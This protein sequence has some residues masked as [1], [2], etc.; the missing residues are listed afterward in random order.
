LKRTNLWLSKK[1]T[2]SNSID[3]EHNCEQQHVNSFAP[4]EAATEEEEKE[5]EEEEEDKEERVAQAKGRK[6]NE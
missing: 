2:S 1:Y 4:L 6:W 5:E 3:L